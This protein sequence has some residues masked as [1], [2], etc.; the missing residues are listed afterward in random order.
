MVEKQKQ[1]G[2][3]DLSLSYLR[4][5]DESPETKSLGLVMQAIKYGIDRNFRELEL[6]MLKAIRVDEKNP[7]AHSQLAHFYLIT[8][9]SNPEGEKSAVEK[10]IVQYEQA[11]ALYP[12]GP[13]NYFG[14]G[15]AYAAK[16]DNARAMDYYQKYL[17]MV[18]SPKGIDK[19]I[20][21]KTY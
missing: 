20:F 2:A 17:R 18:A 15:E 16:G 1:P 12:N 3:P 10:A 19:M 11:I 14:I 9:N 6:N 8:R 13:Q 5:L 21:S 7:N 4:V